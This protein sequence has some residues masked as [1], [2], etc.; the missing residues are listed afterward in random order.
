MEENLNSM[1]SKTDLK[2]QFKEGDLEIPTSV[3]RPLQ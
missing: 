2:G 3:K 1:T